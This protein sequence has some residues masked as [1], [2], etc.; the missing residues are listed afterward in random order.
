MRGAARAV[1]LPAAD[2][3]R[4]TS[5]RVGFATLTAFVARAVAPVD[6]RPDRGRDPGLRER[7]PYRVR[8]GSVDVYLRRPPGG[9]AISVAG[10]GRGSGG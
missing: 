4:L 10:P 5:E 2:P 8:V 6:L 1:R 3:D 7:C 9:P